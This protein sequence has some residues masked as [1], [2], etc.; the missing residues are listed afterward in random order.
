MSV[1]F[2]LLGYCEIRV[3]SADVTAFFDL[4]RAEE[5]APKDI[6]RDEKTGDLTCRMTRLCARRALLLAG[7]HHISLTLVRRGGMP[8]LFLRFVR[9]PALVLG[10]LAALLVL[11]MGHLVL[12][13]IEITGNERLGESEIEAVLAEAGLRR[14]MLLPR[15][16]EDRISLAVRQ[17]DARIS[18]VSV[19]VTGTVAGVQIREA[20]EL[21]P[22]LSSTPANLVAKRDGIILMPLV[23]EGECLV[24]AGDAVRTGQILAS[25]VMDTENNGIRLTRAAGQVLARTEEVFR[26]EIPFEYMEKAYT[27][28]VFRETDLLFFSHSGK[29]FKTTGKMTGTCDI[30][31]KERWISAGARTLPVGLALAE[32]REYTLVTARRSAKEALSLADDTLAAVLAE[33]CVSRTLLGKTVETVMSE[34]GV[35][36]ICTAVF[37]EDIAAV[38]EFSVLR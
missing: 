20:E 27:G 10:T 29:L 32:Y 18:Y 5:F 16:D 8:E 11:I 14:G 13:D 7:E 17:G 15:L 30:I 21:P 19:N 28:R 12:W 38:S 34:T 4:C 35:V 37:E 9:R 24:S 22:P 1:Y 3:I 6:K 23:F 2:W 26:V 36:L 25:G 31:K 33:S